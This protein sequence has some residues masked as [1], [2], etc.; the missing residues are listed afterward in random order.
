MSTA[1][2]PSPAPEAA[3]PPADAAA[4]LG[5]SAKTLANW[6]SLGQGPAY[7][8]YHGRRVAYLVEDLTAYRAAN[9]V[10]GARTAGG[11]QR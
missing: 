11:D 2:H 5:V 7:V 6:R 1:I 4:F 8:Q 10:A 3:L 9:R